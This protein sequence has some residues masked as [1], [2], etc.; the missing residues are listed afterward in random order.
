[1]NL[2]VRELRRLLTY[3]NQDSVV[4]LCVDGLT[5]SGFKDAIDCTHPGQPGDDELSIA[6]QKV[7]EA[8]LASATGKKVIETS[9]AMMQKG[10][11]V[12]LMQ[13]MENTSVPEGGDPFTDGK[14]TGAYVTVEVLTE[15]SEPQH[16]FEP[17]A[18]FSYKPDEADPELKKGFEAL[19]K[20]LESDPNAQKALELLL[21][22][23]YLASKREGVK[24]AAKEVA[25]L[26]RGM[27]H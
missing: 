25:S 23:F 6:M 19:K 21:E 8:M 12:N 14:V 10:T 1:M 5:Y 24:E 4:S 22:K 20:L 11:M 17:I 27:S 3:A 26:A 7:Q 15:E 9:D 18:E 13:V 2:T 16:A